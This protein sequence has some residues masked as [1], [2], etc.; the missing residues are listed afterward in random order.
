MNTVVSGRCS[1]CPFVILLMQ[2]VIFSALASSNSVGSELHNDSDGEPD[3]SAMLHIAFDGLPSFLTGLYDSSSGGF[4]GKERE[5]SIG[6]KPRLESS[7]RALKI[8]DS[9]GV[10]EHLSKEFKLS[11]ST[12]I[13]SFQRSDGWFDDT[14]EK[15][16]YLIRIGRALGYAKACLSLLSIEPTYPF[17][18][19]RKH[20][21]SREFSHYRSSADFRN[22]LTTISKDRK[23]YSI[24]SL[25]NSQVFV[26][27]EFQEEQR[28]KMV[29]VLIHFLKESQ[30]KDG[31]WWDGSA[32]NRISS[33]FKLMSIYR[34][35]DEPMPNSKYIAEYVSD[36]I[37][38]VPA[39]SMA[40]IRNSL[41]LLIYLKSQGVEMVCWSEKEI[42]K[43]S[44][45]YLL[46]LRSK[47]GGF[48]NNNREQD[49][50]VDALTQALYVRNKI[51]KFS[52]TNRDDSR[53]REEIIYLLNKKHTVLEEN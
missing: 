48:L 50:T 13:R 51:Y 41:Q 30:R 52:N 1:I 26:L 17:P 5:K 49:G 16:P 9:L 44:L 42:A 53:M 34:S 2:I 33:A 38:N 35:F 45:D 40:Y 14:S 19:Y 39:T 6:K 12:F 7:C 28:F 18:D 36:T 25:L 29:S 37:L 47:K 46:S 10:I 32:Y 21:N 22:W 4:W 8:L 31:L 20:D 24:G 43:R 11:V 27:R 3:V 23:A 15:R